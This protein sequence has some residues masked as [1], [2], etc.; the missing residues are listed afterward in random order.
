MPELLVD[1]FVPSSVAD[2]SA[3]VL[4]EAGSSEKVTL[5]SSTDVLMM[6]SESGNDTVALDSCCFMK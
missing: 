4:S 2:Y 3:S 6:S 5:E 1:R